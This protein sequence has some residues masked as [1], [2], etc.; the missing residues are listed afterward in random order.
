MTRLKTKVKTDI[1]ATLKGFEVNDSEFIRYSDS[2]TDVRTFSAR[3]QRLK[4][5]NLIDGEF[6]FFRVNAPRG[7]VIVRTK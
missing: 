1:L 4:L 5:D 6:H 2:G 7:V 3:Y